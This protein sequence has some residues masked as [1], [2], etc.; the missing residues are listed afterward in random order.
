[1]KRYGSPKVTVTN[2]L[3]SYGAAVN[4]AG[5]A[6]KQEIGR[7]MINRAENPHLPFRLRERAMLRFQRM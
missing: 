6:N 1:M 3:R 7:W 4:I 5:N 2:R